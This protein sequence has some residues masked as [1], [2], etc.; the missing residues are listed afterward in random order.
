MPHVLFLFS[1]DNAKTATGVHLKPHVLFLFSTDNAEIATGQQLKP[2]AA[3]ELN[4]HML[5]GGKINRQYKKQDHYEI[6]EYW[7][8]W[9][10]TCHIER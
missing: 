3:T 2:L 5:V 4:Q 9:H 7:H 8:I 6:N 10:Q 1:T